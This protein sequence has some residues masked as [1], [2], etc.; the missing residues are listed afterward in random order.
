MR[1]SALIWSVIS[2]TD[3][4]RG[5]LNVEVTHW[6]MCLHALRA[7]RSIETRSLVSTVDLLLTHS[8]I[9]HP[10][11]SVHVLVI[12][13]GDSS[14]PTTPVS[15]LGSRTLLSGCSIAQGSGIGGRGWLPSKVR[16]DITQR[17]E[18]PLS[19]V[20]LT[21]LQRCFTPVRLIRYVWNI[22]QY[23]GN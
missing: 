1:F 15:L 16:V 19:Y 7:S 3:V 8:C 12:M 6:T 22:W 23:H 14:A 18:Q 17:D 10:S 9:H 2:S 4:L 11:S 20:L 13:L 5:S 21:T